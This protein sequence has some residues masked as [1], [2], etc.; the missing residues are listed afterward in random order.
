MN[1]HTSWPACEVCKAGS[2]NKKSNFIYR[3]YVQGSEILLPPDE[4]HLLFLREGKLSIINSEGSHM[5]AAG[6]MALIAFDSEYRITALQDVKLLIHNFST[7]QQTCDNLSVDHLWQ[8][9]NQTEYRYHTLEMTPPMLGLVESMILYLENG[10]HCNYLTQA[11]MME[12]FIAFRFSYSRDQIAGFFYPILYKDLFFPRIVKANYSRARNVAELAE[13]CGY[14]Y[15]NFRKVFAA[16]FDVPPYQWMMQQKALKVKVQLQDLSIPI[17]RI[18]TELGF[19]DQ[20]HLSSFCKR[21]FNAT[22]SQI[23]ENIH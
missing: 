22:P 7:V 10:V 18:V 13:L 20:S 17:K 5:C 14:T 21:Y 23:R 15:A 16:H 3:R 12:L 4:H 8:A 11:K 9:M 6:E 19:V 2:Q 1:H